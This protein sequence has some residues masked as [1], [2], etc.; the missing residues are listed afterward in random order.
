MLGIVFVVACA[1][2]AAQDFGSYSHAD[3]WI[4]MSG[5]FAIADPLEDA[6]TAWA[7]GLIIRPP[8]SQTQRTFGPDHADATATITRGAA[9]AGGTGFVAEPRPIEI[10]SGVPHNFAASA[11]ATGRLGALDNWRA[12]GHAG[13]AALG[14]VRALSS[15]TIE[16]EVMFSGLI[17]QVN[18]LGWHGRLTWGVAFWADRLL[19]APGDGWEHTT[20]DAGAPASPG[21]EVEVLTREF[22]A[23]GPG[24]TVGLTASRW[25]IEVVA[26]ATYGYYAFASADSGL[27]PTPGAAVTLSCGL[28]ASRRRRR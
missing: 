11:S 13:A 20:V 12:S 5:E 17:D 22:T 28:L 26:G 6:L 2:A 27:V 16:F 9:S 19:L 18:W 10:V 3:T 1:G 15:G 25:S 8:V 7:G 23:W 4:G 24:N 14:A 21:G